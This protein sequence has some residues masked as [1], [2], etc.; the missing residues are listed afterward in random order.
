MQEEE[1]EEGGAEGE[2]ARRQ[3]RC[4]GAFWGVDNSERVPIKGESPGQEKAS[5][6][7]APALHPVAVIH[8]HSGAPGGES[9][10]FLIL[11]TRATRPCRENLGPRSARGKVSGDS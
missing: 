6:N 8:I 4:A 7:F 2:R 9:A 5:Q 11:E 3:E 10:A 1:E